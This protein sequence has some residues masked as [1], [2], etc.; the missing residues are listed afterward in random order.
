MERPP[1]SVTPAPWIRDQETIETGF[2]D[3][4]CHAATIEQ[5]PSGLVLAFFGGP[6]RRSGGQALW[7]ARRTAAGWA[8]PRCLVPGAGAEKACW[9]PVLYQVPRGPL[10]L[11]FKEGETCSGWTGKMMRS[12]DAGATF[13]AVEAIPP[14]YWGPIRNR[15]V[16][17]RDGSLLCGSSTEFGRWEVHFERTTTLGRTWTRTASVADAWAFQA[18]QP[19]LLAWPSGLLQALCR[20]RASGIVQTFSAD[21]GQTWMPLEPTGLPNPNSSIDAVLLSDGRALLVYNAAKVEKAGYGGPRTPLSVAVSRDGCTWE[22]VGNLES[23]PGEFSYPCVI[24]TADDLVHVAYTTGIG[25]RGLR[26]AV[27]D[28]AAIPGAR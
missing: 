3:P 14:G 23:E 12:R 8:A 11:F 27:I 17:L 20:T 10:L 19:T 4:M 28:P 22:T 7:F 15:P 13:G 26:H 18:I 21:D 2:R 16:M 25:W 6:D 24:Q 9:N 1:T 5:T